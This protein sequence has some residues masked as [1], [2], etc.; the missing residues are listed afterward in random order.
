MCNSA[1]MWCAERNAR[2]AN[3]KEDRTS[4]VWGAIVAE[5][6]SLPGMCTGFDN[7][8]FAFAEVSVSPT[9]DPEVACFGRGLKCP[10]SVP[11]QKALACLLCYVAA[12]KVEIVI[13]MCSSAQSD[14]SHWLCWKE[15]S[16][17][18]V[19]PSVTIDIVKKL[20][21][22]LQCWGYFLLQKGIL[23]V[24]IKH[25]FYLGRS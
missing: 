5:S 22:P 20:W 23:L 15:C 24:F 8:P 13:A 14:A 16:W 3:D 4:S 1:L 18:F 2:K 12:Q 17:I 10:A 21:T 19:F 7:D 9:G 25:W 11:S 6:L